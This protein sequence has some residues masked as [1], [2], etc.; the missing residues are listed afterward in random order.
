MVVYGPR[1]TAHVEEV[2]SQEYS[3]LYDASQR[4]AGMFLKEVE[5]RQNCDD[6]RR[7]LFLLCHQGLDEG[8]NLLYDVLNLKKNEV[9]PDVELWDNLSA[10]E[11]HQARCM[12]DNNGT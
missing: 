10:V 2:L 5:E 11:D 1:E 8:A 6:T 3:N 9:N 4:L 7:Q 12:Q